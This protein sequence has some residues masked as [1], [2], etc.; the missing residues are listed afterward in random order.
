MKAPLVSV[1]V[2]NWN[3]KEYLEK[4]LPSLEKQTYPKFEVILVDNGST[5]DSL[6]FIE[7]HYSNFVKV[8][9]NPENFGFSRGCN[10]GVQAA[11]GKYIAVLNNDT[12]VDPHWL[13]EL[14]KVAEKDEKVG[15]CATKI[16]SYYDRKT[17]DCVGHLIYP[18][19]LNR[20]RGRLEIDKGQYDKE[21][22]VFSPSGCAALYRNK[23]LEEI[24]LFDETYFAYGEDIDLGI[25]GRLA[26]WKCVYVPSAVVYHMYS[27]TS[28]KYSSL[29][30]F[31]VERNR[32]WVL[33]KLFP[34]PLLI[35]SPVYTLIRYF[36]QAYGAFTH[37]GAS[38]VFVEKLPKVEL[39]ITL[40]KAYASALKGLPAILKKRRLIQ[41]QNKVSLGEF[42][43]WLR[44]FPISAKEISLKE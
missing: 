22:E 28:G 6:N 30:A 24:G 3:G 42:I 40:V 15:M 1:V 27:M 9:R 14:V 43:G 7:K 33:L 38:G 34:L 41:A 19:G 5:D 31:Y 16:Y 17:I 20:G 4:C 26:G 18:D 36:W 35:V 10:T 32:I 39:L 37:Q 29:K 13:E 12:E 21:E 25:R 2:V 44:K 8:I 11:Q 23:M